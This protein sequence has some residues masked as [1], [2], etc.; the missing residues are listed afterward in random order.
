[1]AYHFVSNAVLSVLLIY[2]GTDD[3][4]YQNHELQV[5]RAQ[6]ERAQ[7]TIVGPALYAKPYYDKTMNILSYK[8]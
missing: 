7:S 4:R 3:M 1:M 5:Q 2:A 6:S 8:I